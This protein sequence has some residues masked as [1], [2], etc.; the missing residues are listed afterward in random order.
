MYQFPMYY[1]PGYDQERARELAALCNEA[2]TAFEYH[3]AGPA[4]S[5]VGYDDVTSFV[6]GF[7]ADSIW[8]KL[9]LVIH[10]IQQ[11]RLIRYP[12]YFGFVARRGNDV[13]LVFRGTDSLLD[14]IADIHTDQLLLPDAQLPCS[15]SGSAPHWTGARVEHGVVEIYESLRASVLEAVNRLYS[16]DRRLFVTGHSLGAGLAIA[17]LPDLLRNSK[18]TDAQRPTLYTFAGP[19]VVN[20][21]FALAMREDDIPCFRVVHTED[22]V[23]T[24]PSPI[25]VKWLEQMMKGS[26]YYSHVGTPVDFT[27]AFLP[28]DRCTI[29][30]NHELKT[31]IEALT[32]EAPVIGRPRTLA[33]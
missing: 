31:Y 8:E 28:T 18:F 25:P 19:R 15:A 13:F 26:W 16:P 6:G 7:T 27:R 22:I 30:T 32:Q 12:E 5:P 17:S 24:M 3:D 20:R 2:Y 1:P 9:L 29:R 11:K 10:A 33:G 23:P 14:A 4:P 21:E